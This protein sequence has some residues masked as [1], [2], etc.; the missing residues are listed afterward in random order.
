MEYF[1]V[2]NV[3]LP[4]GLFLLPCYGEKVTSPDYYRRDSMSHAQYLR[5][6]IIE[7]VRAIN[8]PEKPSRLNAVYLFDDIRL[9]MQY[10]EGQKYKYIY[11]VEVEGGAS[12]HKG[13]MT[14]IDMTVCRSV[15]EIRTYAKSY[16][17]SENSMNP[18]HELLLDGK[19][20]VVDRIKE[21]V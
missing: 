1:H 16:Y 4:K 3:E 9:A 13:D 12:I 15:N 6:M 7:E 8:Y 17:S 18:L 19:V 11:Q 5:E 21:L 20:M 10:K 2:T 14:L